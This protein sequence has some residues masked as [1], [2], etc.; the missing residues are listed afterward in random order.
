[1]RR[2]LGVFSIGLAHDLCPG[3]TSE[4]H[5]FKDPPLRGRSRSRV[6]SSSLGAIGCLLN[7]TCRKLTVLLANADVD[8]K[9]LRF[10]LG[11]ILSLKLSPQGKEAVDEQLT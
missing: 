10:L 2:W 4:T 8:A 3:R 1:M 9:N 6:R 7:A 11:F 5:G